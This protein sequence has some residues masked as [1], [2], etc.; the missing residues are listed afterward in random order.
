MWGKRCGLGREHGDG[1]RVKRCHVTVDQGE[2]GPARRM[3]SDTAENE[4]C[5]MVEELRG[6]TRAKGV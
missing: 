6:L 1:H 4:A 3:I 2:V 5:R